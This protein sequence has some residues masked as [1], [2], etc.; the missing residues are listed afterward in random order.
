M[1]S[2]HKSFDPVE[3]L[4]L[5]DYTIVFRDITFPVHKIILASKSVFFQTLFLKDS[6][7]KDHEKECVLS[8]LP[9]IICAN[10][11]RD[12]LDFLYGKVVPWSSPEQCLSV[13]YIAKL[14]GIQR[15]VEDTHAYMMD[16]IAKNPKESIIY[17]CIAYR[18]NDTD[19]LEELYETTLSV[20][21]KWSVEEL[22]HYPPNFVFGILTD[23]IYTYGRIIGPV[24]SFCQT[25]ATEHN[26]P[27]SVLE[28]QPDRIPLLFGRRYMS[29]SEH[30]FHDFF[31]VV[32]DG[33]PCLYPIPIGK[34]QTNSGCVCHYGKKM[35]V[36][37]K[38]YYNSNRLYEI[39]TNTLVIRVRSPKFIEE[40]NTRTSERTFFCLSADKYLFS[41]IRQRDHIHV[42]FSGK[43]RMIT[44]QINP[45]Y[46]TA[47]NRLLSQQ[48]SI[49]SLLICN[50]HMI[51]YPNRRLTHSEALWMYVF[52]FVTC[53]DIR[54]LD[55]DHTTQGFYI[56]WNNGVLDL[57]CNENQQDVF[58]YNPANYTWT[59]YAPLPHPIEDIICHASPVGNR[60]AF[61]LENK[62]TKHV[63]LYD[64]L[65]E[66]NYT[67]CLFSWKTPQFVIRNNAIYAYADTKLFLWN[68]DSHT[69][70]ERPLCLSHCTRML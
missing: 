51:F 23:P 29:K 21:R 67:D 70:I 22:R 30:I 65:D 31:F 57:G 38:S 14:W 3:F 48:Y 25:Y 41:F 27:A 61:V 16:S 44:R 11:L 60:I 53:D 4:H 63:F 49:C 19:V 2:E 58:W 69:W 62:I 45:R 52:D 34:I 40:H 12:V 56:P 50:R 64:P 54:I 13:L 46:P 9:G 28:N 39:D 33:S 20:G 43:T 8:N 5:S 42:G 1:I 59:R 26:I 15:L 17:L 66:T 24:R 36:Q 68:E 10:H 7:W 32:D 55:H 6:P 37:S 18:L 47:T 35:Y